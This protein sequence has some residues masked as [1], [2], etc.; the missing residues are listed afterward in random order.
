MIKFQTVVN[1]AFQGFFSKRLQSLGRKNFR[2]RFKL[3]LQSDNLNEPYKWKKRRIV[4]IYSMSDFFLKKNI[5][6]YYIQKVF[7]GY[8]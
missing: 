1:T 5:P 2:N 7:K 6:V 3:H 8:E 4:F